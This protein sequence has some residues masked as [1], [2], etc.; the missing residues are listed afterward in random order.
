MVAGLI[1]TFSFLA[2]VIASL[3]LLGLAA[4]RA[5][6][7]TKEIGIRKVLGASVGSIV[8]L[9]TFDYVNQIGVAIIVAIPISWYLMNQWLESFDYRIEITGWVFGVAGLLAAAIA[10]VTIIPQTIRAARRNPA[11][12]LKVE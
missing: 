4:F 3:G 10:L 7:R 6:Q 8:K 9:L 2:I 5:E 11:E 12:S 1:N